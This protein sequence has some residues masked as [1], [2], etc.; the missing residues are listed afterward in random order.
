MDGDDSGEEDGADDMS[1]AEN[2]DLSRQQEKN[3]RFKTYIETW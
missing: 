3:N 2:T 1:D